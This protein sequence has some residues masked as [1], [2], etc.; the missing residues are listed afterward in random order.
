MSLKRNLLFNYAAFIYSIAA[1]IVML[2]LYLEFL[3]AEAYG[4]VG[5]AA[6][7]NTWLGL[8]TIGIAPVVIRQVA[9]Y[10]GLGD[11][12]CREFQVLFRS[13]ELATVALAAL[14]ALLAWVAAPW[15]AAHWLT[16]KL[17]PLDQVGHCVALM[18]LTTSIRWCSSLYSSSL[19]AMERQVWLGGAN[20]VFSTLRYVAIYG[21]LRWVSTAPVHYFE[22]QL[23]VSLAELG[24][25]GWKHYAVQRAESDSSGVGLAFSWPALRGIGGFAGGITYTSLLWVLMTQ[26]DKLILSHALPLAEY[27]YLALITVIANG[28]LQLTGPINQAVL[29]RMTMFHSQGNGPALIGLYRKTTQYTS[30]LVFAVAGGVA[31][32]PQALIYALSGNADAGRWGASILFWFALGNAILVVAGMQYFLQYAHGQLRVHVI[33]TTINAAIQ[34][35]V[36]AW[37][38]LHYG[39]L[40]VAVGWF[41]LRCGAFAVWPAIVHSKLAPGM[42][43]GWLCKDVLQ[44]LAGIAAGLLIANGCLAGQMGAQPSRWGIIGAV[45]AAGSLALLCGALAAPD[46]WQ[47]LKHLILRAKARYVNRS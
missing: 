5:F 4:L 3:D 25:L 21:F 41:V 19:S 42:H 40:A 28:L 29:P 17:L 23:A 14:A 37:L 16:V 7:V 12:W 1:S 18:G 24:L 10:R 35:P 34:V 44:P 27:G 32:Y 43:W 15:L 26:T 36:L 22:F 20:M 13:L 6:L 11:L 31:L 33:N 46:S 39:A 9:H 2:P 38:A 47:A 8:L 45:M 30:L